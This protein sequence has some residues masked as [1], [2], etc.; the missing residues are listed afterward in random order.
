M[1]T[2]QEIME[3]G[4]N[5][6]MGEEETSQHSPFLKKKWYSEEEYLEMK[7]AIDKIEIVVNSLKDG[8]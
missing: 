5:E 1:K 3:I 4:I 6:S 2:T 8:E 7:K